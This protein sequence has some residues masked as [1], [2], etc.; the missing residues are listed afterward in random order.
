MILANVSYDLYEKLIVNGLIVIFFVSVSS[1]IRLKEEGRSIFRKIIRGVIIGLL[2]ISTMILSL[3]F[4]SGNIFDA[5]TVILSLAGLFYGP[6]P[7][8]VAWAMALV[9]RIFKGTT[10]LLPGLLTITSASLIGLFWPLFEKRFFKNRYLNF[11][12]LGLVVH[13]VSVL[14]FLISGVD[15]SYF[16]FVLPVFLIIFPLTTLVAGVI[17]DNNAIYY[18]K[19]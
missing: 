6:I 4:E 3:E 19:S 1:L 7:T 13:I 17:A 14:L 11:L 2:T 5:R 10:G 9:F 12:L 18:R 15:S 8:G 16:S